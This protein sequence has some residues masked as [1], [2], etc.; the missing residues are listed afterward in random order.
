MG[1][2]AQSDGHNPPRLFGKLVP[3]LAA[4]VDEIVV[5]FEEAVAEPV[6]A[7]ELSDAFVLYFFCR[8]SQR[9]PSGHLFID[10]FPD[11]R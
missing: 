9:T 6:V 3:S 4:M 1:P 11:L 2:I 8:R 10:E 7:N 5:G